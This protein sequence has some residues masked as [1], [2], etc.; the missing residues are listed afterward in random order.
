MSH[1]DSTKYK[2]GE[3][4]SNL[5]HIVHTSQATTPQSVIDIDID[6]VMWVTIIVNGKK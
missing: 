3:E 2:E 6:I 1:K 5:F 4:N